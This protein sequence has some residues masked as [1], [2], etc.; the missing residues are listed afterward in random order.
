MKI[1]KNENRKFGKYIWLTN[2]FVSGF[3]IL[4]I[5]VK[6]L[7]KCAQGPG[8]LFLDCLLWFSAGLFVGFLLYNYVLKKDIERNKKIKQ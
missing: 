2:H 5:V 1:F 8:L 4:N 7:I 6:L 3:L